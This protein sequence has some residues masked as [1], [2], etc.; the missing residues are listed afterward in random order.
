MKP[1]PR[2][3]NDQLSNTEAAYTFQVLFLEYLCYLTDLAI[4]SYANKEFNL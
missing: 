3:L 2:E 4:Y 1:F